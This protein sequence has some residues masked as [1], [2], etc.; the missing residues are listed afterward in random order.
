[1]AD[2]VVKSGRRRAIIMASQR[3]LDGYRLPDLDRSSDILSRPS[4]ILLAEIDEVE[5]SLASSETWEH[6]ERLASVV[7]R[8]TRL[9]K[10]ASELGLPLIAVRIDSLK[11]RLTSAIRPSA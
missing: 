8:L 3:I 11:E 4:W 2:K 10:S 7:L 6:R 1:M 5:A 9:S